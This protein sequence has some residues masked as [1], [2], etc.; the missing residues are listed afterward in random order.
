M[1]GRK[2]S[3]TIMEVVNILIIV[4]IIA[5][6]TDLILISTQYLHLSKLGNE[7]ARTIAIQSGLQTSTPANYPGGDNGY[8]TTKEIFNF[9]DKNM[10]K[11]NFENYYLKINGT[12][13]SP[14]ISKY[15]DYKDKI[16][17]EIAGEYKWSFLNKFIPGLSKKEHF[18]VA[19]KTV[20]AEYK[21]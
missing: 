15:V 6:L 18:I 13:M 11:S 2:G 9:L 17:V 7:V 21:H 4:L 1:L 10:Q 16:N 5:M 19:K 12:L 3:I 20:Y 14:S 8:Y